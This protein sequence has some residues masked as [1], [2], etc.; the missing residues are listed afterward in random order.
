M[1]VVRHPGMIG[2]TS[3]SAFLLV[4]LSV[5]S[6]CT[7]HAE[8]VEASSYVFRGFNVEDEPSIRANCSGEYGAFRLLELAGGALQAVVRAERTLDGARL[9]YQ[10]AAG[11][12]FEKFD[13]ILKY[14]EWS[15]LVVRF[16]SSGFWSSETKTEVWA[17]DDLRWVIEGCV[18]GRFHSVS[19][20][21][22]REA[23]MNE[24]IEYL[25]ALRREDA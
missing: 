19:L 2:A 10:K 7:A 13:R 11:K 1:L 24:A 8:N 16:D 9:H 4:L 21:P 20:Y 6:P 3:A 15:D 18:N 12:A 17:P 23:Y 22:H 14:A 25:M 5:A